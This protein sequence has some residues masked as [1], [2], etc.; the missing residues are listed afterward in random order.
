MKKKYRK[1]KML[2]EF[3]KNYKS[4]APKERVKNNLLSTKE[5]VVSVTNGACI[6]PDIY[7]DNDRNCDD[8]PYYENCDCNIKKLSNERK[9]KK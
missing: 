6:R 4:E 2:S 9:R 3:A 8:C 1:L 5:G 7:L